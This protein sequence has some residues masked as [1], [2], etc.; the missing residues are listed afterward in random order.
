MPKNDSEIAGLECEFSIDGSIEDEKKL[1]LKRI[2]VDFVQKLQNEI[3][4]R[5]LSCFD[6]SD[7]VFDEL[8]FLDPI[9]AN[10]IFADEKDNVS[11]SKLC[12]LS[13]IENEM[14]AIEEL[15]KLTREFIKYQRSE[16]MF[17]HCFE[18]DTAQQNEE[19]IPVFIESDSDLEEFHMN[20]QSSQNHPMKRNKCCCVQCILEYACASENRLKEYAN[21]VEIYK[22]VSI[23][24]CTQVKCER[25]FSKLKLI[26][27]GLRSQLNEASLNELIIINTEAD[28]FKSIN[29][30]DI[31][32]E[33]VESSDRLSLFVDGMI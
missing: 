22:Y 6:G 2:F 1:E 5:I 4:Q 32:D 26:K 27:T 9:H 17:G 23:L 10:S 19:V 13:G 16:D 12:E 24:P 29:L 14:L 20:S 8:L 3:E 11:I 15:K 31:V 7:Q 28:M 18:S 21:I 33:I 25:D 30:S